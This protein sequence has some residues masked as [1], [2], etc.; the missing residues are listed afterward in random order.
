[1]IG[2]VGE[3]NRSVLA[4]INVAHMEQCTQLSAFVS[5][6]PFNLIGH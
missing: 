3:S 2:T 6:K 4:L 5:E 1:M